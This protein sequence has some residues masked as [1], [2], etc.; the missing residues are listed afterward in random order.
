MGLKRVQKLGDTGQAEAIARKLHIECGGMTAGANALHRVAPLAAIFHSTPDDDL[1]AL[2]WHESRL[3]HFSLISQ[4]ACG[5]FVLLCRRLLL[6]SRREG[7]DIFQASV[8]SLTSH[9]GARAYVVP[10]GMRA[11][12][13]DS[14]ESALEGAACDSSLPLPDDLGCGGFCVEALRAALH[15]V[16]TAVT[17]DDA[18]Q[19]SVEFAGPDNDCP[20]LVGALAGARFGAYQID[21]SEGSKVLQH[22]R[23][24]ITERCRAVA[25]HCS[26]CW[27]AEIPRQLEPSRT[28]LDAQDNDRQN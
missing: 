17:F 4:H 25:A 28:T 10:E 3:T 12:D 20:V 23:E 27:H 6:P 13:R 21:T 19:R 5:I 7:T 16:R 26:R 18:L 24:G 9:D 22:C 1:A 11:C 8:E 2:A 15:F 14:V